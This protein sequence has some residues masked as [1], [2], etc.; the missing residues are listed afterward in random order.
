MNSDKLKRMQALIAKAD[1]YLSKYGVVPNAQRRT[2]AAEHGM[3]DAEGLAESVLR[4]YEAFRKA[5][6]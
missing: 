5:G 4:W 6:A 3:P 1:A 2:A